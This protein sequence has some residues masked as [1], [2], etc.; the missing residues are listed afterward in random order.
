M[1]SLWIY[2]TWITDSKAIYH[3]DTRQ[4]PTTNI[5]F[6]IPS[7]SVGSI[8][9]AKMNLNDPSRC[10][11]S[12][13][14]IVLGIDGVSASLDAKQVNCHNFSITSLRHTEHTL[15]NNFGHMHRSIGDPTYRVEISP[16]DE[17]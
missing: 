4:L 8:Q 3:D 5:Y 9:G 11:F 2:A 13:V 6:C 14:C 7:Q 17:R 10:D 1:V 15:H 16:T 12:T